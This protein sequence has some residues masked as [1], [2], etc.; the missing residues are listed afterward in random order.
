MQPKLLPRLAVISGKAKENHSDN[1]KIK[2]H[3]TRVKHFVVGGATVHAAS[4]TGNGATNA[5]IAVLTM[6]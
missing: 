5:S 3:K 6:T 4:K 1:E 2:Q